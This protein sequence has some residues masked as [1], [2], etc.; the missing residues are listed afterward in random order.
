MASREFDAR[1]AVELYL[2]PRNYVGYNRTQQALTGFLQRSDI[3]QRLAVANEALVQISQ[4]PV[5]Q[6]DGLK[7]AIALLALVI[8]S[9][10]K[11]NI[12][13]ASERQFPLTA[14]N[15]LPV[16]WGLESIEE[17]ETTGSHPELE[18]PISRLKTAFELRFANN[19][20]LWFGSQVGGFRSREMNMAAINTMP[21]GSANPGDY[22]YLRPF[23]DMTAGEVL[24]MPT[25]L[26]DHSFEQM[27]EYMQAFFNPQTNFENGGLGSE[28]GPLAAKLLYEIFFR[29]GAERS[30][31]EK[32]SGEWQRRFVNTLILEMIADGQG[33]VEGKPMQ[34]LAKNIISTVPSSS[35]EGISFL[36]SGYIVDSLS[37]AGLSQRDSRDLVQKWQEYGRSKHLVDPDYLYFNDPIS[38]IGETVSAI[39]NYI[40]PDPYLLPEEIMT[41]RIK[42]QIKANLS[43]ITK[44]QYQKVADLA[45][46]EDNK[47]FSSVLT[48]PQKQIDKARE[49]WARIEEKGVHFLPSSDVIDIVDYDESTDESKFGLKTCSTQF[50]TENNRLS[51]RVRFDFKTGFSVTGEVDSDGVLRFTNQAIEQTDDIVPQGF[52]A[53]LNKTANRLVHDIVVQ[54]RL[55]VTKSTSSQQKEGN[56]D[57]ED[58]SRDDRE[59]GGVHTDRVRNLPR[60]AWARSSKQIKETTKRV[61]QLY[62]DAHPALLPYSNDYFNSISEHLLLLDYIQKMDYRPHFLP[63]FL[64]QLKGAVDNIASRRER[65]FRPSP[66]KLETVPP[67]MGL[68]RVWDPSMDLEKWEDGFIVE[69]WVK[70]KGSEDGQTVHRRN[71]QHP[72]SAFDWED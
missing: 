8:G 22:P 4:A 35:F 20:K 58:S 13:G 41:P 69:T 18:I 56:T 65:V 64:S 34:K 42:D 36:V 24:S 15:Q 28:T 7:R 37:G 53:Y 14:L 68:L 38:I 71:A 3:D 55:G 62:R 16:A 61:S 25:P 43:G 10:P 49:A 39:P 47:I 66:Q 50:L 21:V 32:L 5:F 23:A 2:F 48:N 59:Q 52:K 30:A 46:R 26:N 27:S 11:N 31:L 72:D 40:N 63:V 33:D 45:S 67:L 19:R 1:Q 57:E 6:G 9:D 60:N 12:S 17:M 70:A 54:R 44:V 51:A 29:R